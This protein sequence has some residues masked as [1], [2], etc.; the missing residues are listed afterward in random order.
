MADVTNELLAKLI[1]EHREETR[2]EFSVLQTK[3]DR[4]EQRLDGIA[5]RIDILATRVSAP[6][7]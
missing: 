3:I 2:A 6:S 1:T 5:A 4:L 7:E